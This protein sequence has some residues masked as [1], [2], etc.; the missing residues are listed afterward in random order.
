MENITKYS[1]WGMSIIIILSSWAVIKIPMLLNEA[2][3]LGA[4]FMIIRWLLTVIAIGLHI[5]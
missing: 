2:K 4:K 5:F 3:F 1:I